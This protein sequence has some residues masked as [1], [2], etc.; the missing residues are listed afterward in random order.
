MEERKAWDKKLH[1]LIAG[2]TETERR[3][4][5]FLFPEPSPLAQ[6]RSALSEGEILL[7]YMLGTRGVVP[8][9]RRRREGSRAGRLGH[10]I[11]GGARS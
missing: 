10:P 11:A 3:A 4:A 7:M 2:S 1:E 9:S 8:Y 6:V 5:N